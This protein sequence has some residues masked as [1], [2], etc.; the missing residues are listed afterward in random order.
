MAEVG[1]DSNV[2]VIDWYNFIVQHNPTPP[3]FKTGKG[4]AYETELRDKKHGRIYR[5][6]AKSDQPDSAFSL[7]DATPEKL[8]ATLKND[9]LLWRRHAQRLLV[10]RGK[11][12]VVPALIDLVHEPGVDAISLNVGAIHA[13]WTLH[14]LGLLDGQNDAATAAATA[15]LGHKSPGVRRNALQVLPHK[16]AAKAILDGKLLNDPDTQ[17]RLAA[18]LALAETPPN[19]EAAAAILAML[20]RPENA[21]DRWIPDAAV[22]A[23]AAHD[24]PFLKAAA[25]AKTPVART[26][27]VVG[28]VAEH[29]ARGADHHVRR[30]GRGPRRRRPEDGRGDPCRFG[31]GLAEGQARPTRRR[32]RQG[33]GDPA[34]TP[35][36]RRQVERGPTCGPVGQ[37]RLGQ[38]NVQDRR[39]A[40]DGVRRSEKVG[41]A[42][43]AAARQVFESRPEDADLVEK[44]LEAVTPQN[45]PDLNAGLLDALT[46]GRS[47]NLG[48]ALVKRLSGWSPA[49]RNAALRVLL[50][51]PETARVFLEAAER[52]EASLS[53]LSLD[54]K[55]ALIAHPEKSIAALAK[56]VMERGGGLPNADRQK[57]VE[58]PLPLT[59][60]HRRRRGG[61]ARLQKQLRQVPHARRR[62][63]QGRPRPE[64]RGRSY[65]GA[66]AHRRDGPEP[67]RGG[68]ATASSSWKPTTA[69]C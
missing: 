23:A 12:D 46:L 42:R 69:K 68:Q 41:G 37:H 18:L 66:F 50:R 55:Q 47:A 40:G 49:T 64:R 38:G 9:N 5:L 22:S 51:R 43:I 33:A 35:A 45:S 34:R 57:V 26:L 63:R 10:E 2:W 8:V 54:Q 59:N 11:T 17:V 48:P 6:V 58:A 53:D 19:A 21:G 32:R 20:D 24:L 67:R 62:G 52:G 1:P 14:G 28:V 25:G 3:G 39:F 27:Q 56:K 61:Q 31:E 4:N 13:L 15:A 36:G 65:Q 30:S 44:L 16:D 7:K 29:Y 60:A